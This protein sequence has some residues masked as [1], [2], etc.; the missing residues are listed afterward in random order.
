MKVLR[1]H[2]FIQSL[3]LN[4]IPD[5]PT[6]SKNPHTE[7]FGRSAHF[8]IAEIKAAEATK[9]QPAHFVYLLWWPSRRPR[10]GNLWFH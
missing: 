4:K 6:P 8:S 5:F 2:Y 3:N 1:N 7:F 10:V 9:L